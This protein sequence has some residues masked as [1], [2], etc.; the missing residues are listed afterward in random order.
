MQN[1]VNAK[2]KRS[3][4]EIKTGYYIYFTFLIQIGL[5]LFASI[6]H[7]LYLK[8]YQTEFSSWVEYE[9]VNLFVLFL[10]RLGNWILIFGYFN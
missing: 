2:Y 3:Q 7:I 6:Y 1:N 4:L 10:I 5:C 9:T 8:A